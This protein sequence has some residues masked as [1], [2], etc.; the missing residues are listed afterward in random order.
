MLSK[1]KQI[2][3]NI[4]PR[5]DPHFGSIQCGNDTS[6]VEPFQK[7]DF[8]LSIGFIIVTVISVPFGILN[9]GQIHFQQYQYNISL[10]IFTTYCNIWYEIKYY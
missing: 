7:G 3:L 9:L 2:G 1:K 5:K 10:D 6:N 4:E 8:V